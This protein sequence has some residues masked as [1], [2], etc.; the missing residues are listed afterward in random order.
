MCEKREGKKSEKVKS[1]KVT[2]MLVNLWLGVL[3][4]KED[5]SKLQWLDL[6]RLITIL[7]L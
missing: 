2:A 6:S 3:P 1:E 4:C 7:H 5:N